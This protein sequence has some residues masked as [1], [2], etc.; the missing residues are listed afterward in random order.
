MSLQV[1]HEPPRAIAVLRLHLGK[2]GRTLRPELIGLALVL[3]PTVILALGLMM[4][5]D[6]VLDYPSEALS[7]LLPAG[8][9]LLP[10][11]LWSREGLFDRGSFQHLPV[12]RRKH[13]LIR[14][15]A[16]AAWA[17]GVAAGVVLL[18]NLLARAAGSPTIGPAVWQ[19]L[20]PLGAVATAYLL[21]SAL[22]LAVR[23]PLRWSA[24]SILAFM[25]LGAF[26]S[27]IAG[28]LS[29]GDLAF[30]RVLTGGDSSAEWALALLFWFG[31]GLTAVAVASLRHREG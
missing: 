27:P 29:N 22:V 24:G 15:C 11:R 16:G 20:V 14:V 23:H 1:H 21:G 3:S 25:L 10:F 5:R 26:A 31:L 7:I 4:R 6:A 19:W 17:L 18:F 9:F 12:E 8:G 2:V 30:E 28:A 13:V